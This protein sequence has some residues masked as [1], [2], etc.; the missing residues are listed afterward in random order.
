[1]V[2]LKP[3]QRHG[4]AVLI[5]F[6]IIAILVARLN[7][8][9][10]EQELTAQMEELL[11][12]RQASDST[13]VINPKPFDP[14]TVELSQLLNLGLTKYEALSILRYR[15]SGKV[16]HIKEELIGCWGISDSLYFA[17]EPY[18]VIA[19]EFQYRS[20]TTETK[21]T[22]RATTKEEAPKPKPFKLDTVTAQYIASHALLTLRQAEVMLRWHATSHISN[23]EEL[24]ECYVV[25]DS[26]AELMA[27]YII[28]TPEPI[29]KP[30]SSSSIQKI[31]TLININ[32]A[33][34]AT[35]RRVRGIGAK[36]VVAI[37]ERRE[38]L[39]G[40]HSVYQLQEIEVIL[41]DNFEKI[42]TQIFVDSC[43][44]SKIDINFASATELSIHPY[45][46]K[47]QIRRILHLRQL[48]GGWSNIERM[49]DDDIFT[50]QEAQL[51]RPYLNFM[52]P[53]SELL[54]EKQ[55]KMVVND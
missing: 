4:L 54:N 39:G 7:R 43:D 15:A 51:V 10:N 28:F 17:L 22:Y 36:S 27:Q 8:N 31:D 35:L 20:Q 42:I 44:I 2:G 33:D 48:K 5:L 21:S 19:E 3:M 23:I 45:L 12:V 53:D 16:F 24:R 6:I 18:I 46:T 40:F 52:L 50:S 41:K 34:S 38:E 32:T 11:E 37:L 9:S 47:R 13:V 30:E 1:M 14:N 26:A 49:I 29:S 55:S 25:S